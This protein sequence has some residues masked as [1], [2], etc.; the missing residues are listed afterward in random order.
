MN[1]ATRRQTKFEP[2]VHLKIA[3]CPIT[4]V[5]SHCLC[6]RDEFSR[7]L[8]KTPQNA[9]ESDLEEMAD[10]VRR[11][12]GQTADLHITTSHKNICLEDKISIE[13]WPCGGECLADVRGQSLEGRVVGDHR[14]WDAAPLQ[15]L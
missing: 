10:G 7:L 3:S 4:L 15:F 9:S 1:D 12:A 5:V 13:C 6:R 8:L 11:A 14:S 2:T